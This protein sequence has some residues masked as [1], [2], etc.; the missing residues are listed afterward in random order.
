[1]RGQVLGVDRDTGDGHISGDDGLRYTFRPGDWADSTGPSVGALIDFQSEE[2]RA[3]KIYRQPGTFPVASA[4]VV[5]RGGRNK[6]IAALLAFF[7]GMLGVHRFYLGRTGS[8]I[9]MLALSITVVGMAATFIWSLIDTVR[10]LAMPE[11]EFAHLY[12]YPALT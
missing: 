10:Y 7:L 2:T 9:L 1:M 6:Y 3:R 5:R 12:S 11:E 8:G 4:P